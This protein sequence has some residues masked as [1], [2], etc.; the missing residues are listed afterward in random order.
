MIH[1]ANLLIL[2]SFLL[3][4]ILL[5]RLLSISASICFSA[6][7]YFRPVPEWEPIAWNALFMAVNAYQC[8][9][10]F[11]ERRPVHLNLEEQ[12]VYQMVFRSLTPREF[13]KLLQIAQWK[14]VQ[15]EEQVVEKGIFL[16]Q[17]MVIVS[18][19]LAVHCSEEQRILLKEG[20]FVGE[21]SFLTNEKTSADVFVAEP[22][23]LLVWRK[24]ELQT[25]LD[26]H[27]S[28]CASMQLVIGN[29]LIRKLNT[30]G[31]DA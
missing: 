21:M 11:M 15:I 19:G 4:D 13:F 3:K 17:I 14:E 10:L 20:Q 24:E 16:Q 26:G 6:Y 28:L 18:G 22:T 25:F 30:S 7:F 29:D 12:K 27:P 31:G 23:R 1:V 5:L 2:V 8:W 9:I